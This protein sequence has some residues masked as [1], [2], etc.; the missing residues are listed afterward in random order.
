VEE[1]DLHIHELVDNPNDY[2]P[3]QMI[4]IQLARF[5]VALEGGIKGK[6]RKM[7]FIHGVGNGRLKHEIR[8]ELEKNYSKY[9]YQDASFR[10]YGFG[11]TMVFLKG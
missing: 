2:T 5:K 6:T 8:K 11:A 10:E 7:V 3:G 4:E 1:V 9:R